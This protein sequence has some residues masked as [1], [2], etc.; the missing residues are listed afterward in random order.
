MEFSNSAQLQP[1]SRTR[2]GP[3]R[4]NQRSRRTARRSSSATDRGST[5]GDTMSSGG[6]LNTGRFHITSERDT[7]L[8]RAGGS[9]RRSGRKSVIGRCMTANDAKTEANVNC[10]VNFPENQRLWFPPRRSNAAVNGHSRLSWCGVGIVGARNTGVPHWIFLRVRTRSPSI[11]PP[12]EGFISLRRC[13]GE[14]IGAGATIRIIV[15]RWRDI[16]QNS[17]GS[18]RRRVRSRHCLWVE[19]SAAGC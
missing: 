15:T 13:S 12:S 9:G 14:F 11:P 8:T 3:G 18:G 7:T 10:A 19:P 1:N 6:A 2:P 5:A 16:E 4:V 17:R